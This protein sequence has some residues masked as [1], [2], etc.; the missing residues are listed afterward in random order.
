MDITEIIEIDWLSWNINGHFIRMLGIVQQ[1]L[2][3][4]LCLWVGYLTTVYY[5]TQSD[6]NDSCPQKDK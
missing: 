6:I 2:Q 3:S 5:R 4:H 1:T